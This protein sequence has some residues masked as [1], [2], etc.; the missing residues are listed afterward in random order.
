[1]TGVAIVE[2]APIRFRLW[3]YQ[4][5]RSRNLARRAEFFNDGGWKY[6]VECRFDCKVATPYIANRRPL[7]IAFV[8]NMDHES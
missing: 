6:H 3:R 2:K 7:Q 8:L 4:T 1:M 5:R